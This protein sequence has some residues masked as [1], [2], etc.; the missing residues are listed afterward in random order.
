MIRCR[1]LNFKIVDFISMVKKYSV[2]RFAP[3]PVRV[4]DMLP[5]GERFFSPYSKNLSPCGKFNDIDAKCKQKS[6]IFPVREPAKDRLFILYLEDLP[7]GE[8]FLPYGDKK[9]SPCGN[10]SRTR[11]GRGA[12]W[13]TLYFLNFNIK[14]ETVE[15]SK[16]NFIS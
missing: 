10:L 12:T 14:N 3:R 15:S 7:H 11:T 4:L 13:R 16:I 6:A 5:Y 2:C 1:I 8:R 9:L